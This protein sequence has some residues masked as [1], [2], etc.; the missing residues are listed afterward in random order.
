MMMFAAKDGDKIT[1][2][3]YTGASMDTLDNKLINVAM[4][5]DLFKQTIKE[6]EAKSINDKFVGEV[7]ITPHCLN[8]LL[9]IYSMIGLRDNSLITDVSVLKDKIGQVVA[10]EKLTWHANPRTVSVGQAITSDGFVAEDMP[11]IEKGVL[12]NHMLSQYGSNKTGRERSKNTSGNFVI[13]TGNIT[14]EEMIKNV[15]KGILL[16]RFSGGNPS[17]D[18]NFSGVAKNSFYIE[19]GQVMYP[20][21]ETMISGN[22]FKIFEDIKDVSSESVNFGSSELP[23]IHTGNATISG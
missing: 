16:C 5:E 18:G 14:L 8:E 23:W 19:K 10:N 13:E 21:S 6:L 11:I 12:K 3:N 9:Y 20:I 1:S 7:I 17:A 2:F 22:L 4:L 15:D